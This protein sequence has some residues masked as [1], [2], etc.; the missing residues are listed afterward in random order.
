MGATSDAARFPPEQRERMRQA[1]LGELIRAR[2][3]AVAAGVPAEA[4][5][6][7]LDERRRAIEAGT[8]PSPDTG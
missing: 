5:A 3:T 8:G 1:I 4:V 7:L 2:D 6:E